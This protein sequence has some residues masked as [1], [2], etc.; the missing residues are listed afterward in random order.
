MKYKKIKLLWP[1]NVLLNDNNLLETTTLVAKLSDTETTPEEMKAFIL[2]N[3]FMLSRNYLDGF[4][5]TFF[6]EN[7]LLINF[8]I[9]SVGKVSDFKNLC[10]NFCKMFDKLEDEKHK[11]IPL[12]ELVDLRKRTSGF[13]CVPFKSKF[14]NISYAFCDD[15]TIVFGHAQNVSFYDPKEHENFI[16]KANKDQVAMLKMLFGFL[17]YKEVF[18]EAIKNGFVFTEK[19]PPFSIES[20][21]ISITVHDKIKQSSITNKM[22]HLRRGH[23]MHLQSEKYVKKRGSFIWRAAT[24]INGKVKS[25]KIV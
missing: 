9:N 4:V 7:D 20:T 21:S 3:I 15:G 16:K 12:K 2:G 8:F 23:F 10:D 18:P 17:L 25:I 1:S 19:A 14:Q 11:V 24:F 5:T 6:I 13:L 22:P